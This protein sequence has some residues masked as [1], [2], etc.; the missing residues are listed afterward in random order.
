MVLGT[1][2]WA[3]SSFNSNERQQEQQQLEP[4]SPDER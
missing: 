2:E 4:E 1:S 3:L